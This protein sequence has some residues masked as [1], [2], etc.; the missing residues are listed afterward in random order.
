MVV[1]FAPFFKSQIAIGFCNS[2]IALLGSSTTWKPNDWRLVFMLCTGK[3]PS[4]ASL[5]NTTLARF[6]NASTS[7]LEGILRRTF[8]NLGG[9]LG[10]EGV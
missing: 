8:S 3:V 4:G 7:A 6:L 5:L 10:L 2:V 1:I 9:F